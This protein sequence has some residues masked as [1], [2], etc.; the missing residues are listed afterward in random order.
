M[1]EVGRKAAITDADVVDLVSTTFR[2]ENIRL[3]RYFYD[4]RNS[5]AEIVGKLRKEASD[6]LVRAR[7]IIRNRI[8]QYGVAEPM[9]TTQ[10]NR[11]IIIELPGISDEN[12]MTK[13]SERN[14]KAGVQAS[15]RK[16]GSFK[17]S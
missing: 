8:D 9:I 15:E 10:G 3:S 11:K 4:I 14:R 6:A 1:E 16:W 12:R 7:E 5:D 17:N 2:K 13:P